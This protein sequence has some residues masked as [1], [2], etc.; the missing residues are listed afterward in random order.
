MKFALL[1][2]HYFEDHRYFLVHTV[3]Y[4]HVDLIDIRKCFIP[5][6]YI[7]LEEW[8]SVFYRLRCFSTYLHFICL[9]AMSEWI[10]G[11]PAMGGC[12]STCVP[13]L[14]ASGMARR[15]VLKFGAWLPARDPLFKC[16]TNVLG[17]EHLNVRIPF[18]SQ[19]RSNASC[20]YL[21]WR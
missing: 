8:S 4:L 2:C 9:E 5:I 20:W 14:H 17:V 6:I 16:F 3:A 7:F 21:M 13:F 11:T 12:I 15:I 18:I 10:V 1:P 19:E